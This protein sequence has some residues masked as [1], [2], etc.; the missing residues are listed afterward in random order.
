[1]GFCVGS[2]CNV[3]YGY[4]EIMSDLI[5]ITPANFDEHKK[6][7]IQIINDIQIEDLDINFEMSLKNG[8]LMGNHANQ[9]DA[10]N[11]FHYLMAFVIN[12]H[13]LTVDT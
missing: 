4:D 1:M 6:R 12:K 9:C 13:R 2:W 10:C 8:V 3:S 5:P 7:I 11:V